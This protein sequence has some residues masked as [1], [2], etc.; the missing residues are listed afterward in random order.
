[1]KNRMA[2]EIKRA[3][4]F[5]FLALGLAAGPA[6]AAEGQIKGGGGPA[7]ETLRLGEEM[8]LRGI[9]P[10]GKPMKA[11]VQ[12][13]I[14]LEGNMST[15]SNC[16]LRSGMGSLEGGVLTL[17]T[18]GI[19]LYAPLKGQQDIP[20][21]I[22]KR[23]TF[24]NPR[25]AYS[26]ASLA[27]ALRYGIDPAGRKMNETM[28]RYLLDDDAMKVMV[29]YL[30][31]LTSTISPGVTDKEIRFATIVTEDVSPGDKD[32]ML[33]PLTAYMRDS[34]NERIAQ[35]PN[36]Y[37]QLSA[38]TVKTARKTSL[39]VW[40]LKGPPETWKSQLE[41]FYRQKPVFAVLGGIVTGKWTPVHEFCEQNKIPCIFPF[42]D[43]PVVSETDWYTL[44]FS[45]GL[46][47]EG[48]TAAKYLSRVFDLPP[49]KKIVQIFRDNDTGNALA[50]GFAD[51]WTKL[52]NAAITNRIVAANEKIG[53]DFWK[54]LARTYPDAVML[55]WLGPADLAG[56]ETFG[57]NPSPLFLSATLFS[58]EF[59]SIPDSVRGFTFITYPTRLPDD[60]E[61]SKPIMTHL[62][63]L[64][65]FSPAD[66]KISTKAY[67]LSLMV[68]NAL[69]DMGGDFYRD[70]FLDI[71]DSGKDQPN[72]SVTYPMLS[73]GPG[74]R[75]ASK[76][77]YVVTLTKG[78]KPQVVRQSDWVVY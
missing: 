26:D 67:F 47:Q 20:G 4:L 60:E 21:P 54:S 69:N 35:L 14:E 6:V 30:K 2:L 59:A 19:K 52:G 76:G 40:E 11:V 41:A 31:N 62:M 43:L 9:L 42:T 45:K 61:Y 16:H 70:F 10:S 1:M 50:R 56:I 32:A 24:R 15:C 29:A 18:N 23:V 36:T 65:K 8:Y 5:V 68:T 39:D 51:T 73:F 28:P 74:Q 12:E 27:N 17:P 72:N 22:M 7:E 78:E 53:A 46:Y 77:C 48:E 75:Y 3:F 44:Y 58:G 38:L 66:L 25:P 64:K 37:W 55:V 57:H 34:W 13:D 71:L 33:L 63:K 49:E